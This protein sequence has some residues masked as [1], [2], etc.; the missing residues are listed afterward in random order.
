[1]NPSSLINISL[2]IVYRSTMLSNHAVIMLIRMVSKTE[3]G[4]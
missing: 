2:E 4:L 1:M 3:E